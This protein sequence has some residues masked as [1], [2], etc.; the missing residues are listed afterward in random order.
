MRYFHVYFVL[1]IIS[2]EDRDRRFLNKSIVAENRVLLFCLREI[3]RCTLTPRTNLET[4]VL[5]LNADVEARLLA[6]SDRFFF[7][8]CFFSPN[9]LGQCSGLFTVPEGPNFELKIHKIRLPYNQSYGPLSLLYLLGPGVCGLT[10]ILPMTKLG[11]L[12]IA[13]SNTSPKIRQERLLE[14]EGFD[15]LSR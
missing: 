8:K 7:P 15:W 2:F 5:F 11:F 4:Y 12:A 6:E 13:D 9:V 1:N 14:F 3:L 10:E